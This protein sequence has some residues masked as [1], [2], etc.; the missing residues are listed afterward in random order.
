MANPMDELIN[1]TLAAYIQDTAPR[2]G[3][4]LYIDRENKQL[5]EELKALRDRKLIEDD[6]SSL[7]PQATEAELFAQVGQ[8]FNLILVVLLSAGKVDNRKLFRSQPFPDSI[9]AVNFTRAIEDLV[10]VGVSVRQ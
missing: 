4:G 2:E 9:T 6:E 8:Q 3:P 1:R 10:I 7:D 5:I